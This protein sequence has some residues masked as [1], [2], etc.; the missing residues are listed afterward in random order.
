MSTVSKRDSQPQPWPFVGITGVAVLAIVA[1]TSVIDGMRHGADA[2]RAVAPQGSI[3]QSGTLVGWA[4]GAR[5]TRADP[6]VIEFDEISHAVRLA[7]KD[8]F[9]YG[10]YLLRIAEVRQIQHAGGQK[11]FLQVVARIQPR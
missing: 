1:L 6:S 2:S 8:E 9:E 11:S 3:F 7:Q 4:S 10:G 5:I